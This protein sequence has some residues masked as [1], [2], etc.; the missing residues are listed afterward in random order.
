MNHNYKIL[1]AFILG[2]LLRILSKPWV[3]SWSDDNYS[4]H[5]NKIYDA[6]LIGSFTGLVLILIDSSLLTNTE[7]IFWII[8]FISVAAICNHV[9]NNQVLIDEKEYI[10]K[11]KEDSAE[12]IKLSNVIMLN[13]NIN[14]QF[15]FYLIRNNELKEK[16]INE[17]NELLKNF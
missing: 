3:L 15:K 11:L 2:T 6:M 5:K 16:S 10:I 4:I 9:I 7:M 14:Q 1:L 17:L 8:I 12:A 13:K